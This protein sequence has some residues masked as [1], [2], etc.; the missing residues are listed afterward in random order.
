VPY[1][2][3]ITVP[4]PPLIS[5]AKPPPKPSRL[6]TDNFERRVLELLFLLS[7]SLLFLAVLVV[8]VIFIRLCRPPFPPQR[9]PASNPRLFDIELIRA[10][11]GQTSGV[12]GSV[13]RCDRGIST[14]TAAATTSPLQ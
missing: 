14:G 8:L 2:S 11:P 6:S 13:Y 3:P 1:S 9:L 5:S 12:G 4:I 7:L 10:R